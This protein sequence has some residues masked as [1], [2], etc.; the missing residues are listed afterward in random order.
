MKLISSSFTASRASIHKAFLGSKY[1]IKVGRC[2]YKLPDDVSK[3][4]IF[5]EQDNMTGWRMLVIIILAFT[6]IGIILAIPL[7][8]AGKKKRFTMAFKMKDGETFS[9]FTTNNSEAEALRGY[10]G[11]GVFNV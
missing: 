9:V 2:K 8:F 10:A 1:I 5:S 6:L 4:K 7:Y 11:I 3:S